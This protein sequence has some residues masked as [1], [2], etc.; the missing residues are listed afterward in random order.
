MSVPICSSIVFLQS[1]LHPTSHCGTTVR[2]SQ[3][4]LPIRGDPGWELRGSVMFNSDSS[5][6]MVVY[7]GII[8]GYNGI[9]MGY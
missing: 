3:R 6:E 1:L 4:S 7:I 9:T 2:T 8:V 5:E